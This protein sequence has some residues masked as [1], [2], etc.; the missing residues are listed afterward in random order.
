MNFL[1]ITLI[2]W[3]NFRHYDD[4]D[5]TGKEMGLIE[6]LLAGV[7]LQISWDGRGLIMPELGTA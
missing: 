5:L 2:I 7:N 1:G 6:A 3:D 4:G